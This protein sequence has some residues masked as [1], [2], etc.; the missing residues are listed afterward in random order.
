MAKR[1]LTRTQ[2][3]LMLFGGL[4]LLSWMWWN[5]A[6]R[7]EEFERATA[8]IQASMPQTAGVEGT[9]RIRDEVP[10]VPVTLERMVKEGAR[11]RWFWIRAGDTAWDFAYPDEGVDDETFA[12]WEAA[13]DPVW[14]E[15]RRELGALREEF[16]EPSRVKGEIRVPPA[17]AGRVP[18]G[19]T[20]RV[21]DLFLQAGY[22]DVVFEGAPGPAPE[23]APE[24]SAVEA[25][26][27]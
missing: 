8:R 22:Q 7:T 1:P 14:E 26:D 3:W 17:S 27:R 10:L 9:A 24:G 6:R 18:P 11:F 4:I 21:L 15:V 23:A 2:L 20:I 25:D 13:M 16:R 19:L 5:H 12:G